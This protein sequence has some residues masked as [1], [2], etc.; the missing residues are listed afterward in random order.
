VCCGQRQSAHPSKFSL[1]SATSTVTFEIK[2]P[3]AEIQLGS[4]IGRN[5]YVKTDSLYASLRDFAES[6]VADPGLLDGAAATS[7]TA[8]IL[9]AKPPRF[10]SRSHLDE[11]GPVRDIEE[12]VRAACDLDKSYLFIQGPPGTGKTFTGARVALALAREGFKVGVTSVAHKTVENFFGEVLDAVGDVTDV[13]FGRLESGV[14]NAR[15]RIPVQ[16]GIDG[17]FSTRNLVKSFKYD[18]SG[19]ALRFPAHEKVRDEGF[20]FLIIDEAGQVSLADALAVSMAARNVIVLGDPQQLPQVA[21]ASHEGVAGLSVMQ[22]LIGA[23]NSVIGRDKGI[24]LDTSW[25]MHPSI[26]NFISTTFYAGQLL[27]E[28]DCSQIEL[29]G[30]GTGMTWIDAHHQGR[31]SSSP[32]EAQQ[33][34]DLIVELLGTRYRDRWGVESLLEAKP[35]HFIIIAPYNAQRRLIRQYLRENPETEAL[36]ECVGTVD[37]FQGREAAVM[38]YSMTSSSDDDISRTS[39]FLFS[40]ERFNVAVSRA[41]AHAFVVADREILDSRVNSVELMKKISGVLAFDESIW[42]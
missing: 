40:R 32:E 14:S 31:S 28:Q 15:A 34:R 23:G 29:G 33:V 21:Q 42:R 3:A 13:T 2:E 5:E 18:I 37:K 4:S 30:P 36:A 26:C 9:L 1:D 17:M 39:A 20:D 7:V 6:V 24:L 12:I 22:H 10:M 41:K 35:E 38:I 19:G 11:F 8:E 16:S 27:P 25:R